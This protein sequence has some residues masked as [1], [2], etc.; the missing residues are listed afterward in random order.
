[1]ATKTRN[2]GMARSAAEDLTGKL[3][4]FG[5]INGDDK[6]ALAT[7]GKQGFP[8]Q[9]VD[10]ADRDA[11]IEFSGMSKCK[12]GG[13]VAAEDYLKTDAQGRAVKANSGD[14]YCGKANMPGVSGDVI[15]FFIDQGFVPA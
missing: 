15:Q 5:F 4:H 14:A 11:T 6:I 2:P 12:L 10:K 3:Y 13:T 1:M 9:A 8:L 7:S